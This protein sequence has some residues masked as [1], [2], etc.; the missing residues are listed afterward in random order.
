MIWHIKEKWFN[1]LLWKK[2][3]NP[4]SFSKFDLSFKGE[5]NFQKGG[6]GVFS[7]Y[8]VNCTA[9]ILPFFTDNHLT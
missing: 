4:A 9:G 6:G 7:H 8:K 1:I 5:K 2:G 3:N